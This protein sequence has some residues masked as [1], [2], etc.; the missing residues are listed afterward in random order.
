MAEPVVTRPEHIRRLLEEFELALANARGLPELQA[1]RDRFLGRKS[2]AV[3][4]LLKS[5]AGLAADQKREAGQQLNALKTDIEARLEAARTAIEAQDRSAQ[6]ERERLDV[7][8]PGRQPAL[9][10]RH[11]LTL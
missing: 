7:T 5:L 6:L 11:P 9:G 2:G 10:R 3:T 8:L 4:G 1:L